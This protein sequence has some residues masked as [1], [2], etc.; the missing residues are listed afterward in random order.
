VTRKLIAWV[1]LAW[2]FTL[3][4]LTRMWLRPFRRGRDL[5]RFDAAVAPEGY[6]PLEPAAR[7]EFVRYMGCVQCGLCAIACPSLQAQPASAWTEAWTFVT[8]ASRSLDRVRLVAAQLPECAREPAATAV[9][10]AGVP[11]ARMAEI[12]ER[13]AMP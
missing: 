5:A 11:I 12:I 3:H 7:A 9:C 2:H 1:N 10:P 8:G 4:V 13:M 6:L